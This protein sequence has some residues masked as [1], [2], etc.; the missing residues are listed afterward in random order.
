MRLLGSQG[1]L[2]ADLANATRKAVGF[3]N[4]LVHEFIQVSDEI[5]T[6]RLD[7]LGDI[8]RFVEYVA[9][10]IAASTESS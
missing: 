9:E 7:D 8:E 2:T 3:R 5:V 4:I 10:F 6:A 1:V